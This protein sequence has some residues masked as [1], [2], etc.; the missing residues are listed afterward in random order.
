IARVVSSMEDPANTKTVAIGGYSMSKIK[1]VCPIT[2]TENIC[3]ESDAIT[4]RLSHSATDI[5]QCE[6]GS[7][8][9]TNKTFCITKEGL[10]QICKQG[11]PPHT[12]CD[13]PNCPN[14]SNP[15]NFVNTVDSSLTFCDQHYEEVLKQFDKL[16][17]DKE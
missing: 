10:A 14:A 7:E 12:L 17:E 8:L 3:E 13:I 16:T 15:S 11:Q 2:G 9:P 4:I 5:F 1:Y 6:I